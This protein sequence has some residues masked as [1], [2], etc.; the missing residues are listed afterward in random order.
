MNIAEKKL[1]PG[2]V[3][4]IS[5]DSDVIDDIEQAFSICMEEASVECTGYK[6]DI[7]GLVK[8]LNPGLVIVDLDG[9]DI[10]GSK[11][12]GK[13]KSILPVPVITISYA[14][15]EDTLIKSLENGS[16]GHL[17]KPVRQ[18]ELI[19]HVRAVMRRVH[20]G[21]LFSEA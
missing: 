4:V 8:T 6:Q 16:D 19:A 18:L 21:R 14:R 5:D 1:N 20:L 15:D 3:L 12:L 17:A 13:L 10:G 11:I 7:S 2:L 9:R